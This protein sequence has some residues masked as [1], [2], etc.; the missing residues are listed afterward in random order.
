[1]S[2]TGP[3]P[4]SDS[5]ATPWRTAVACLLFVGV[6]FLGYTGH[7]G[8]AAL[9][10]LAGLA[11]LPFARLD[12]SQAVVF[13]ALGALLLWGLATMPWSPATPDLH[14]LHRYKDWERIVGL[15][16]V[17]QLITFG[18]LPL[19]LSRLSQAGA[20][21][22]SRV[23]AWSLVATGLLLLEE[24]LTRGR[25]LEGLHRLLGHPV[26]SDLAPIRASILGNGLALL[27]WPAA[28]VL[29]WERR[30]GWIA[31]FPLAIVADKLG[32]DADAQPLAFLLAA[33][34][35]GAVYLWRRAALVVA[36]W[37]IWIYWL[38]TPAILGLLERA[39]VFAWGAQHLP[40]SYVARLQIWSFAG[41][42]IRRKP[43]FGWGLDSARS[44]P[45]I[46][47]LHT[48][49]A[50]MQVWLE[51][52]GLGAGLM[53]LVWTALIWAIGRTRGERLFCAAAAAT[54]AAYTLIGAISFGVWQEWWLALGAI[55]AAG[56]A[57]LW[58]WWPRRDPAERAPSIVVVQ[59]L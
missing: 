29:W 57:V 26:R 51:L 58:R 19:A 40:P 52:G 5:A 37:A 17:L 2:T 53:A 39:G 18:A 31:L 49:D 33:V 10:A 4:A 27:A 45:G 9:A 21:R 41:R 6:P 48:H 38:G 50:A 20:R 44:W 43:L 28:L 42:L 22:A 24:S 1:M 13:A 36:A 16:L 15:K 32:L 11:V 34:V 59:P 14:A 54:L 55:C 47:P 12:R 3:A 35:F 7:Q 46:I 30:A 23:L 8:Y 56:L 25:V